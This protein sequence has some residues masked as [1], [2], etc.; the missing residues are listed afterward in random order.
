MRNRDDALQRETEIS[1]EI[2]KLR[3]RER[4]QGVSAETQ[5]RQLKLEQSAIRE[6]HPKAFPKTTK[7]KRQ[8]PVAE[9]RPHP[10]YQPHKR[11]SRAQPNH[12]FQKDREA[13]LHRGDVV[14]TAPATQA[15][16]LTCSHCGKA[17]PAEY[18]PIQI[19][20]P[21]RA[22]RA[23]EK[24]A[25]LQPKQPSQRRKRGKRN[26][27][28]IGS[29]QP[30]PTNPPRPPATESAVKPSRKPQATL[31]FAVL[32][33]GTTTRAFTEEQK[34]KRGP[35]DWSWHYDHRRTDV[36]DRLIRHYGVSNCT[37]YQGTWT[38]PNSTFAG[39]NITEDYLILTIEGR[40]GPTAVA[41][42]PAA[43]KHATYIVRSDVSIL[44]WQAILSMNKVDAKRHGARK[45]N[46]VASPGR[47]P[48]ESMFQKVRRLINC[49][50][51]NFTS[52]S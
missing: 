36:L 31:S 41:I 13:Q 3:L 27:R 47:T 51:R 12:Q 48:Y 9:Y 30:P 20:P 19:C 34:R 7:K 33:P 11:T 17:F 29:S 1:L 37:L 22:T 8:K 15:R 45:L 46:F 6:A 5:I 28:G 24:R 26:R 50:A 44:S 25:A 39:R 21:C 52:I 49:S 14:D 10:A 4:L 35:G 16:L 2:D 43:R 42:S 38:G 18:V 32:P 23:R 40:N